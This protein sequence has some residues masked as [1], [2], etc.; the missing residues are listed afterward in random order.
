M[1]AAPPDTPSAARWTVAQAV[2]VLQR[3]VLDPAGYRRQRNR[4]MREDFARREILLEAARWRTAEERSLSVSF[5]LG[6]AYPPGTPR[7]AVDFVV[8]E[9][10]L[11]SSFLLPTVD[12]DALSSELVAGV[13]GQVLSFLEA[14]LSMEQMVDDLLSDTLNG[15]ETPN[16]P[17]I[18]LMR[19]PGRPYLV[20]A[21]GAALLGDRERYQRGVDLAIAEE[22]LGQFTPDYQ[23]QRVAELEQ[24]WVLRQ[25][26][27]T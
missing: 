27:S 2:S 25:G 15:P 14:P 21:W 7:G 22:P 12:K 26:A 9:G 13:A 8:I 4:C 11:R 6:W 5:Q 3:D 20:A 10:C 16:P 19:P 23:A 17:G 24:F 1:P 18:N